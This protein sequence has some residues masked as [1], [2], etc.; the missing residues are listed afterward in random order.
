MHFTRLVHI[1]VARSRY[2]S[3]PHPHTRYITPHGG[4]CG[5]PG[6]AVWRVDYS[7]LAAGESVQLEADSD[8]IVDDDGIGGVST[9]GGFCM[10][11]TTFG[12]LEVWAGP[13][14]EGKVCHHHSFSKVISHMYFLTHAFACRWEWCCSIALQRRKTSPRAGRISVRVGRCRC[15][16][17]GLQLIAALRQESLQRWLR[18]TQQ[19]C[20][21]SHL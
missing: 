4:C 11:L 12:G 3:G 10:G 6:G 1:F 15:E 8:S 2:G 14:V 16:T 19:C 21:C 5:P 7:K 13:L 20:W 17:C 9:T 18:H